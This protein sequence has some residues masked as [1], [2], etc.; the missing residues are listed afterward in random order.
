MKKSTGRK[1]V[2]LRCWFP[3]WSDWAKHC[4]AI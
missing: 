1:N 4:Y 3:W 2:S